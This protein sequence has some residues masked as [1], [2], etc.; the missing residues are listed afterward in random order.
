MKVGDRVKFLNAT[1]G[2]IIKR[3]I[4]SRMVL[5]TIEGGFEIPVLSSEL[6]RVDP[7]DVK[8][9]FFDAT[10]HREEK[11]TEAEEVPEEQPDKLS[12]KAIQDRKS[13]DVLL[14][15][16]PHDQKW[17]ITGLLDIFMINNSSYDVLYSQFR[18]EADGSFRGVDYGSVEAGS[19]L[20]MATIERDDL[21]EWIEGTFQFLFHKEHCGEVPLPYHADFSI[22]G[23]KFYTEANY[24]ESP[25]LS[26]KSIVIRIATIPV[27]TIPV[28]IPEKESLVESRSTYYDDFILKHQTGEKE[29]V[30]DLHIHELLEDSEE[31][32]KTE[33]L[34]YQKNYF[35]RC[36]ESAVVN[37]FRKVIFI[38]GV[39]NGVLREVVLDHLLKQKGIDV[40][41][42]P[43]QKYGVGAVEVRIAHNL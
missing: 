39:G 30:V 3:V 7:Q 15:F 35:L 26:G 23:K 41:D 12:K 22:Q 32:Q 2:G 25:L 31:L 5:I 38:H 37:H 27:T 33:I 13:E 1:G 43:M 18:K 42:A 34:E 21:P 11:E 4:D 16:L 28:A 8:E 29:A 19:K 10:Y 24:R 17:L 40:F 36:L 14:G 9:R 6:L 20:L